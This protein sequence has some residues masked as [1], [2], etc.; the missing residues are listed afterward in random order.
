MTELGR[1]FRTSLKEDLAV[2][3]D[4]QILSVH[5]AVLGQEE[6]QQLIFIAGH[7]LFNKSN[8][9]HTARRCR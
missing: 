2:A 1:E 7:E 9:E 5:N 3:V 4:V 8:A 6:Q